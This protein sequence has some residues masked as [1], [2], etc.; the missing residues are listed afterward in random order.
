[1]MRT[2]EPEHLSMPQEIAA[3]EAIKPL[4]LTLGEPAGIGPDITLQAWQR[5]EASAVPAFYLLGDPDLLAQ[6]ATLLGLDV[7][8]AEVHPEQAASGFADAL[9][10]VPTEDRAT[11]L[12]GRPDGSS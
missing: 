11:A 7:P 10:V 9:P 12:P 4:A 6:R 3:K 2:S 8:I 5:R 1:M